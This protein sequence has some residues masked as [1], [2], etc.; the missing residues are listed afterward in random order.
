MLPY[1][2][3]T[4]Y[5]IAL[6]TALLLHSETILNHTVQCLIDQLSVRH[7]LNHIFLCTIDG[8]TKVRVSVFGKLRLNA[9][10]TEVIVITPE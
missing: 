4:A 8:K 3:A 7:Q 5:A 1:G 2:C 10:Q 9:F 6:H